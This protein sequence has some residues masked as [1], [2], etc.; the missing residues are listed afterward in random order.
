MKPGYYIDSFGDIAVVYP[1]KE[2]DILVFDLDKGWMYFRF[3]RVKAQPGYRE[4][5]FLAPL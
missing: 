2:S 4:W 5:T 3:K 1:S